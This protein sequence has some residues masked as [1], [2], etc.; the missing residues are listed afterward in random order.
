MLFGEDL[1]EAQA[2]QLVQA[3]AQAFEYFARRSAT[4]FVIPEWCGFCPGVHN[5]SRRRC[6]CIDNSMIHH[7]PSLTS[8]IHP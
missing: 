6:S 5:S 8:S 3:V 2:S 7:E 4:G 1:D